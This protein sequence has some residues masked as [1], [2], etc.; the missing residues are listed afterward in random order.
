MDFRLVLGVRSLIAVVGLVSGLGPVVVRDATPA[1]TRLTLPAD[2][3]VAG[4]GLAERSAR[5]WQWC[6]SSPV[7]PPP[8]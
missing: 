6:F 3:E 1:P 7:E 5:S 4:L 2:A 8:F